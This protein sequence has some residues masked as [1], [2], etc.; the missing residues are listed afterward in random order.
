MADKVLDPEKLPKNKGLPFARIDKKE[1]DGEGEHQILVV[2][3]TPNLSGEGRSLGEIQAEVY[4]VGNYTR[5]QIEE[6]RAEG[7]TDT[8]LGD[9]Y[10][11]E[12]M[13]NHFVTYAPDTPGGAEEISGFARGYGYHVRVMPTKRRRSPRRE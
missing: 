2:M 1:I 11:N 13:E 8:K 7:I 12:D 4:W 10:E 6:H 9:E 3:W 5:E